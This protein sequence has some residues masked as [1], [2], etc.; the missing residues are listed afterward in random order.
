MNV[1][2]VRCVVTA[3][4]RTFKNHIL[5]LITVTG[6]NPEQ[7]DTGVMPTPVDKPIVEPPLPVPIGRY[8]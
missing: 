2:Y 3:T 6:K 1:V 4:Q 5:P 7:K 8:F